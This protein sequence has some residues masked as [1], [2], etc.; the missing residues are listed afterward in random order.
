[1]LAAPSVADRL[2]DASLA[3]AAARGW[4]AL[5]MV[6]V[7]REAGVSL[8]DTFDHFRSKSDLLIA[9]LTRIDRQTLDVEAGAEGSARDRLFEVI[10]RRFDALQ[11]QRPA[12]AAIL[13]DLPRDPLTSLPLI[14]RFAQSMLWMLE[15]AGISTAAPFGLLRAKGLALVYLST[16]R[17]WLS[18]DSPDLSRTMATLDKALTR[19][20]SLVR[21]LPMM[22]G[23]AAAASAA[24]AADAGTVGPADQN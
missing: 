19:A 16:M 14:P 13:R 18:D 21:R 20:D 8:A 15:A 1:M 24:E 2:I 9:L 12:I 3:L 11:A 4:S 5:T 17:S 6:E 7:A 10:M 22:G 23:P